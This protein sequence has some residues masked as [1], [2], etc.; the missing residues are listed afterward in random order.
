MLQKESDRCENE[1]RT[2]LAQGREDL[3]LAALRQKAGLRGQ[4]NDL[5]GLYASLQRVRSGA[6]DRDAAARRVELQMT[7]LAESSGELERRAD[8]ARAAGQPGLAQESLARKNAAEAELGELREQYQSLRQQAGRLAAAS[9]RLQA[10]IIDLG[11]RQKGVGERRGH[12]GLTSYEAWYVT[13]AEFLGAKLATLD[14]R[15]ALVP[16]PRCGFCLPPPPPGFSA[17]ESLQASCSQINSPPPASSGMVASLFS[18]RGAHRSACGHPGSS[19]L[20]VGVSMA[21]RIS[22]LVLKCR[23]PEVLARFWCEILDFVELDREEQVL[24][25]IGPREGFGGPQ[26]TIILIRDD[27]PKSGHARLHIDV[28]PTDRDQDA[29]LERILAARGQTH[30]TASLRRPPGTCSPIQ[31]AMS[32]PCS[33]AAL[34][35]SDGPRRAS[36]AVAA[37]FMRPLQLGC[38]RGELA[39]AQGR[40]LL[41]GDD[42]LDLLHVGPLFAGSHGC[43]QVYRVRPRADR[44]RR[45][46]RVPAGAEVP[47]QQLV[48]RREVPVARGLPG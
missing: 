18:L 32:S 40:A 35:H 37:G 44:A 10:E 1:A 16:G 26:P 46:G 28:N 22:E 8:E 9:Q 41:M 2:A 11:L 21:C 12:P 24:I 23:D 36:T 25:E 45:A 5:R 13:L 29:E 6:A 39:D 30:D 3:A 38:K 33:S 27:E 17:P 48:I 34:T 43:R 31:K 4:L 15:L 14:T 42:D 47:R 19:T 7:A 20:K